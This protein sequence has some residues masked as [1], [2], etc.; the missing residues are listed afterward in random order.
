MGNLT[1]KIAKDGGKRRVSHE[2]AETQ[3]REEPQIDA[4]GKMGYFMPRWG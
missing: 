4:D 1:A 3:I 2:G